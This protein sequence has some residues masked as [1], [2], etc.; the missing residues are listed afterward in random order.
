MHVHAEPSLDASQEWT[1]PALQTLA[2]RRGSVVTPVLFHWLVG[3]WQSEMWTGCVS[4]L[5]ALPFLSPATQDAPHTDVGTFSSL[6]SAAGA[7]LPVSCGLLMT[8]TIL[9]VTRWF[10]NR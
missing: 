1:L 9:H 7:V 4:C 2:S 6:S 3:Q 8:R 5:L 10:P